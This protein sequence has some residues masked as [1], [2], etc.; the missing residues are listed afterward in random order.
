M[1]LWDAASGKELR[2][3]RG[4]T[5]W[6]VGAAFAQGGKGVLTCA[7]D[8]TVRLWSADTGAEVRRFASAAECLAVPPRPS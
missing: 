8:G 1:R 7:R 5:G 6:V 2:C 3:L 4:H